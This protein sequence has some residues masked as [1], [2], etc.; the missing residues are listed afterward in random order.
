[1]V[2]TFLGIKV[3]AQVE[4]PRDT[5]FTLQG[6]FLKEQKY[7]SYIRIA[8]PKLDR[9]IQ[10]KLDIAYD[11]LG[12]RVLLLDAFYPKVFPQAAGK[13]YPAVI[14][15]HGGGW[16]SG[17]K[18]QMHAIGQVLAAHG[19]AAFAVE[20]RLSPEAKYP[21]AV[22]DLKTAV[23]WI[24]AHADEFQVDVDRL[25]SLGTSAGGQLASLLGFTNGDAFFEGRN[26]VY[27]SDIQAVVNIDGTLAFHHPESEEGTAAANW[28][29]GVYAEQTANWESAAPLNHVSSTAAPTLFI[30]SAIP[31]FHAGRDD[32]TDKLDKYNIYWERHTFPDTPHPFWFFDPWFS[33]MMDHILHFLDHQFK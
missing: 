32:T 18:S 23:Q 10:S 30:N 12:Q 19:Y 29:G 21:A 15:I 28:F 22:K 25:A 9:Q 31:R 20:H 7:R 6:T 33:P 17:D 14:L 13:A 24:R 3:H 16:Q 8:E 27:A 1:M 4:V 11:T 26:T 2:L 5:S